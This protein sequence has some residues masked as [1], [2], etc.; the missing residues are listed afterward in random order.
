MNLTAAKPL[1]AT[2]T[3]QGA[4]GLG[5][6]DSLRLLCAGGAY[7]AYMLQGERQGEGSHLWMGLSPPNSVT[8]VSTSFAKLGGRLGRPILIGLVGALQDHSTQ[9]DNG[10]DV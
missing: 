3:L 8:Y 2:N 6:S 10:I 4:A 7:C 1:L 9:T 5:F